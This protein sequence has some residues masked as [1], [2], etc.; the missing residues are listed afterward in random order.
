MSAQNAY[1]LWRQYTGGARPTEG[2]SLQGYR[3]ASTQ[4]D[5]QIG[6][7]QGEAL[8]GFVNSL[9]EFGG[10]FATFKQ[11]KKEETDE[12]TKQWLQKRT[13]AEARQELQLKQTGFEQDPI[14][15]AA[16][17]NRMGF[18]ISTQ[19]DADVEAKV[20]TGFF[21][22]QEE[23]DEYRTNSLNEA[24]RNF[25][26]E[27]GITEDDEAF[28]AGWT[29]AEDQRRSALANLQADQTNKYRETQAAAV[30][31]AS[32]IS[33]MTPE[34]LSNL[35]DS[36]FTSAVQR[37]IETDKQAGLTRNAAAE[38]EDMTAVLDHLKGVNGS[39]PKMLALG[40]HQIDVDG[41]KVTL[42][43]AMGGS[44]FDLAVLEAGNQQQ[45]L[46]A[47]A[48]T[49]RQVQVG[50][51]VTNR[52]ITGIQL[53][54]DKAMVSSRG[55]TTPEIQYLQQQLST[56]TQLI[57]QDKAIAEA[58]AAEA[59]AK[60]GRLQGA[61][62]AFLSHHN[63]SAFLT[64]TTPEG[65]GVKSE[66]EAQKAERMFLQGFDPKDQPG[67]ALKLAILRPGG[68]ASKALQATASQA[69]ADWN[70]YVTRLKNGEQPELP[71]SVQN[72]QAVFTSNPTGFLGAIHPGSRQ[73][74]N[75]FVIARTLNRDLASVAQ[76][77]A[78]YERLPKADKDVLTKQKDALK[79]K[80][81][82]GLSD[83]ELQ[84]T[85]LLTGD[86]LRTGIG[87]DA[88]F[89]KARESFN[90]QHTRISGT[91][92]HNSI[93]QVDPD[94]PASVEWG[95]RILEATVADR[96][97]KQKVPQDRILLHYSAEKRTVTLVD[98]QTGRTL[99]AAGQ[100]DIRNKWAETLKA[101]EKKKPGY[102]RALIDQLNRKNE[103]AKNRSQVKPKDSPET[104]FLFN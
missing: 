85:D 100:S 101:E 39:V 17:Y 31:R 96:S 67:V 74:V 2:S 80:F 61:V 19:V 49:K 27:A 66:D 69:S 76:S 63:G 62:G 56:V 77:Q 92:V 13:I 57:E 84:A 73:Y 50:Q 53:Q 32:Y 7:T 51:M 90:E 95:K 81:A 26:F 58:Q 52:D 38:L 72:M 16:L 25:R 14:A 20:K 55:Q 36:Q 93:L 34:V 86:F 29:R 99:G 48:N 97:T 104:M 88:A 87:P 3:A 24:N 42:R 64:A 35:D 78:A 43:E 4:R 40:D 60:N 22:S 41:N 65:L 75:Q 30:K 102:T 79:A 98:V 1:M 9:T 21:K 6:K 45:R 68:M 59:L 47:V 71:T 44:K 37:M 23:L 15:M 8:N 89:E 83:Y 46:D 18:N 94:R 91:P 12:A 11:Q 28:N 10:Q 82:R 70:D 5:Q 33:W 54:L 103:E